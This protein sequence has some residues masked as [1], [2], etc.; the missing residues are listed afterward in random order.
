[1]LATQIRVISAIM[2]RNIRTRFF[3]HGLGFLIAMSWPIGHIALL[4]AIRAWADRVAPYGDSLTLFFATGLAPFMAFQYISRYTMVSVLQTRPLLTY[5]LVK[6]LDLL[7]AGAILEVLSSCC[8]LVTLAIALEA[9]DIDFVPLYPVQ[10]AFALSTAMLL[11]VSYGIVN[12][13]IAMA[14]PG[15]LIVNGL[16]TIVL[17]AT[18]GIFFLPSAMSPTI[19]Y[20]LSFNPALQVVEWM[21]SAYYDGYASVLDKPYAVS[22]GVAL[23]FVGLAVE[24]IFRGRFLIVG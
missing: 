13:L 24:R 15:W 10:A 3:G 18:S 23:L 14:A 8:W 22:F 12:S 11:G 17:Y 2:L 1:M 4:L 6:I 7:F 19:R 20:I 5:P 21:R 16:I 9:I